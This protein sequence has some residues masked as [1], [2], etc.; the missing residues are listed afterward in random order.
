MDG[1][2]ESIVVDHHGSL[3]HLD[4]LFESNIGLPKAKPLKRLGYGCLRL[5][6]S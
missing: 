2:F 3:K 6:D 1:R 5:R 4:T